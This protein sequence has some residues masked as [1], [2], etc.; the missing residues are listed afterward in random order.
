MYYV[1]QWVKGDGEKHTVSSIAVCRARYLRYVRAGCDLRFTD[2]ADQW[3]RFL[4]QFRTKAKAQAF[5]AK[6]AADLKFGR[7][8][9]EIK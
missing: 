4:R 7:R 5:A 8:K 1:G 6:L 9:P 2:H 3:F